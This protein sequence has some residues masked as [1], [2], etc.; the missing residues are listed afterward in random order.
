[1]IMYCTI[2]RTY[3]QYIK[4]TIHNTNGGKKKEILFNVL[5]KYKN[6]K[7]IF[8]FRS[9]VC[10]YVCMYNLHFVQGGVGGPPILPKLMGNGFFS[11]S[12]FSNR[13]RFC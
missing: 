7:G 3:V 5:Q 6:Q 10:M 4:I 8:S 9:E 13:R 2:P 1:M 12:L 11:L